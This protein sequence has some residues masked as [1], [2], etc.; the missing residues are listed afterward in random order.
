MAGDIGSDSLVADASVTAVTV[1]GKPVGQVFGVGHSF[2]FLLDDDRDVPRG[3][4]AY[5]QDAQLA[6]EHQ[7]RCMAIAMR[8]ELMLD[9]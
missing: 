9:T 3:P 4:F 7:A 1:D 6:A 8:W 2:Y 5:E